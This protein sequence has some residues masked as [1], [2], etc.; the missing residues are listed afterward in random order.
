M[1]VDQ[2]YK[3]LEQEEQQAQ[4]ERVRLTEI[5]EQRQRILQQLQET[6]HFAGLYKELAKLLGPDY[7]QR[8][9]LQKAEKGIVF[10]ANE[11]LD[12]ISGGVLRLEL[13]EAADQG[14]K[15]LNLVAYNRSIDAEMPQPIS[16]LSGSQQFRASVSLALG[17]GKYASHDNRRVE[18]VIIDEG[19]GSLD[20][21]G[22]QDMIGVIRD[23]LKNV[24]KSII[25]V[26]HQS[27][28]FDEFEN[29]YYL[30]LVEGSTQVSLV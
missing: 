29:K 24:L 1:R 12:R 21:K 28:I 20:L 27:E 13:I 19:F 15:A 6:R 10:Y 18:S 14:T 25:V 8:Y 26:S 11:F 17:I 7:L 5:L 2:E 30:S 3:E 9:L 4:S 23:E 22:R 16:N